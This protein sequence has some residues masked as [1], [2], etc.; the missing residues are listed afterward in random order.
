MQSNARQVS[1]LY[2]FVITFA[3]SW[4]IWIPLA[5]SHLGIGP[6]HIAEEISAVVRLLG[7]LMP[8]VSA[9]FLTGYVGGG[10]AVSNLLRRL[11]IWRVGWR[12]WVAGALGQPVLLF[13]AVLFNNIF[14]GQPLS[15]TN[16]SLTLAGVLV[17]IFFLLLATLGEEIGWRGVALPGLQQRFSPLWASVILAFIWGS[18]HVPFWLLLDTFDQFGIGY[19]LLNLLLG[20][21]LT[22]YITWFYNHSQ[23]SLLLAVVFHLTFNV[24]N[25]IWLPVTTNLVAFGIAIVLEWLLA[26]FIFRHLDV[27]PAEPSGG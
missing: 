15:L 24:A 11:T 1:P 6:F 4:L 10:R 25:T 26:L 7:V 20:I 2:F 5:F 27:S 17:N 8:A 23:S 3:I 12:W 22:L 21:P 16:P 13:I 19:L 18:W 9:L 14:G